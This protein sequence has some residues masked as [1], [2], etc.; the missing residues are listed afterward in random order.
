MPPL[1]WDCL[2][3]HLT[4]AALWI[5]TGTLI[6]F[7]A[8]D[9]LQYAHFPINGEIFACWFLLPFN[10]DLLVNTMNF[11]ITL[12]GGIACYA[13]A[14][15]LGLGKKHASFAPL[16][17]C[18]SPMI[19]PLITTQYVDLAV[20]A[21]CCSAVLF[22]LRYLKEG[23]PGDAIWALIAA[24][25]ALGVKFTGIAMAGLVFAAVVVKTLRSNRYPGFFTKTAII[26][27][28]LLIVCALGGRQ[29]I[30]NAID[31]GNPLYPLPLRI[32]NHEIFKG[33]CGVDQ[34]N[35][36]IAEYET[37]EGLD[38]LGPWD[39]MYRKFCYL[40]LNAGP[41]F[42]PFLFLAL[43]SLF[44]TTHAIPKRY[45]GFLF[46]MWIIPC[47]A[48]YAGTS[49]D[50]AKKG[51]YLD[52]STRFLSPCVAIFTIQGLA[53]ISRMKNHSRSIDVLLIGL[54]GWNLL[55][56]KK[57]HLEEVGMAY[58]FIVVLMLMG[59]ALYNLGYERFGPAF[60]DRKK[61]PR[62]AGSGGFYSITLQRWPAYCV[63]FILLV[64]M[65]Y[66]LQIYRDD[67]RYAY[68]RDHVDL[69]PIPGDTVNGWE[70]L[71]NPRE[72]KTIAL[73]MDWAAPGHN[74]FFYPL[75]G[76]WLQN[77][78]VYLSAKYKEAVP[79][80]L[81]RGMLRGDELSVWLYNLEKEKVDY[82]LARTP[83]PIEVRWMENRKDTF[84]LV[85]SDA[86]FKIFRYRGDKE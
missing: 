38:K 2:T 79:V 84:E 41:T 24:G 52:S 18:F 45:C 32:M 6:V 13:I 49:M 75:L 67:T 3:Y 29:Y 10:N 28:G 33:W 44:I 9:Q 48:Y 36:W 27:L 80:R 53:V 19:F 30:R 55:Y 25:V 71:D 15:E 85:V 43:A 50:F 20:F 65:L 66:I 60:T 74:W 54:F 68:Y 22:A 51:Y 1:A 14:R 39:R 8:P 63:S 77:D 37:S 21:F 62:S 31:A 34:M 86:A 23:Y 42:A 46:L 61:L 82:I 17:I 59:L 72:K 78:V 83:W 70:F 81:H 7:S 5:K 64:L 69:N 11:P 26:L 35:E 40:S 12:L 73:A 16:L 58:P 56:M 47:V 4:A 57:T 76:R